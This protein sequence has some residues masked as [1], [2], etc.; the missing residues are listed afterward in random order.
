MYI[1]KIGGDETRLLLAI[2]KEEREKL[3]N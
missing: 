3:Y 1:D 2:Y